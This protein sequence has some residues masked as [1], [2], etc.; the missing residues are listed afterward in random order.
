VRVAVDE[1]RRMK[2]DELEA[3]VRIWI[4]SRE[5]NQPWL[6]ARM[7]YGHADSLRHFRD[8][9]ARENEVWVA[10]AGGALVGL[11]A[12]RPGFVDQLYVDP[13]AQRRGVGTALLDHAK[14]AHPSGLALFTHQAN[15][16]ARAFYERHGM[17]AVAFG[18][19]PS[20][21]CEPDVR[22]AWDPR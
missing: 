8:V 6:E 11:M 10:V 21:E 3:V 7:A 19:S 20:P 22:Y 16:R 15:T 13:G 2:A 5:H 9:I 14:R 12:L 17:R 18:V 1:I 4:E